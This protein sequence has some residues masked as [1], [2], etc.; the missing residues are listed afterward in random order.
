MHASKVQ[1]YLIGKTDL[2]AAGSGQ[3]MHLLVQANLLILK[4]N[5]FDVHVI[6]GSLVMYIG[7][8]TCS[9]RFVLN[10]KKMAPILSP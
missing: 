3:S 7:G 4:N 5:D 2:N 8:K 1:E 6:L 10:A 9:I